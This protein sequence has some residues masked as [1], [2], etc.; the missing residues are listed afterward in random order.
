MLCIFC[1][2]HLLLTQ[3]GEAGPVKARGNIRIPPA[4]LKDILVRQPSLVTHI[5]K[6]PCSI[7]L[8]VGRPVTSETDLQV[9]LGRPVDLSVDVLLES[10]VPKSI[11]AKC[12]LTIE[13]RCGKKRHPGATDCNGTRNK[14]YFW[15]GKLRHSVAMS[16]P[17]ENH[18]A[19]IAFCVPG[20]Y[21][22]S[23]CIKISQI[24][25]LHEEVWWAPIAQNI[26]ANQPKLESSN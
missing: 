4:C 16:S 20:R 18:K 11:S 26:T 25:C 10:W 7:E 21:V 14:E 13:F 24:G 6:P 15:A 1:H 17:T 19:K 9:V 3:G 5:C 23:A 22:V 2:R 8:F 12:S